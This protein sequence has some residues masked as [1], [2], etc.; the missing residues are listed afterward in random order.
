VTESTLDSCDY[1]GQENDI[2]C[3]FRYINNVDP[4]SVIRANMLSAKGKQMNCT[5]GR[6]LLYMSRQHLFAEYMIKTK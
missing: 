3:G 2:F 5:K 1:E 6:S 4:I